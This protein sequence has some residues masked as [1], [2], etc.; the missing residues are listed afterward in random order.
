MVSKSYTE[1]FLDPRWQR[2][3]T[4][5]M[6]RADFRCEWCGSNKYTLHIHHGY[7]ESGTDPWDYHNDTLYCLCEHCHEYAE[8][9]KRD[10]H[11]ELA[12]LHPKFWM[13]FMGFLLDFKEQA[14]AGKILK[15]EMS[16]EV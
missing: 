10:I 15:E 7:Y 2:K 3:R 13:A 11:M 12:S 16:S 9:R 8:E 5:I 1:K 14:S 4:E 6:Q